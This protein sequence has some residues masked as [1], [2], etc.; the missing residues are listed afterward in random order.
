MSNTQPYVDDH[1]ILNRYKDLVCGLVRHELGRIRGMT[2]CDSISRPS[3]DAS[4]DGTFDVRLHDAFCSDDSDTVY[5]VDYAATVTL[6][7]RVLFYEL[8][9]LACEPPGSDDV[10]DALYD[11]G[12]DD[13]PFPLGGGI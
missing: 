11:D 6:I 13:L 8:S 12:L 3:V 1:M 4:A 7:G 2:F 10:L 5:D 9:V